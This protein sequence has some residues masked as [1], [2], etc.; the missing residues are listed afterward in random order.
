MLSLKAFNEARNHVNQ[1]IVNRVADILSQRLEIGDYDE[2]QSIEG[3]YVQMKVRTVLN[4]AEVAALREQCTSTGW[5]ELTV[6]TD[7]FVGDKRESQMFMLW[8]ERHRR[9]T[10]GGQHRQ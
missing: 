7:I 1:A 10:S 3:R 6:I 9:K 4:E 5:K 2:G 8:S